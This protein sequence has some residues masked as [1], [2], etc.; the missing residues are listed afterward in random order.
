M[1]TSAVVIALH[2]AER[3]VL[4]ALR[5]AGAVAPGSAVDLPDM[6]RLEAFRLRRLLDAGVVHEADLGRYYLDER[7]YR[8]F[9]NERRIRVIG[10]AAIAL[11]VV[12]WFAIF[13]AGRMVRGG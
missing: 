11:A 9:R 13:A 1:G 4:E 7:A 5:K 3:R 12:C 2:R 8:A 6:R 10:L